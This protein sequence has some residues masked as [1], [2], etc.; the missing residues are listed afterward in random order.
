MLLCLLM[1]GSG[2]AQRSADDLHRK[3]EQAATLTD[4]AEAWKIC[5][6]LMLMP[7]SAS[8]RFKIIDLYVNAGLRY[9]QKELERR[10][11]DFKKLQDI[12]RQVYSYAVKE[13]RWEIRDAEARLAM[14]QAVYYSQRSKVDSTYLCLT[15]AYDGCTASGGKS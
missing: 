13:E 3:M 6:E 8:D 12:L 5:D 15:R 2:Y 1:A 10:S 7:S 4:E 14:T 9:V 11:T